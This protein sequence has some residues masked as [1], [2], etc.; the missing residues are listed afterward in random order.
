MPSLAVGRLLRSAGQSRHQP[1]HEAK[2]P[3]QL[4]NGFYLR[5]LFASLCSGFLLAAHVLHAPAGTLSIAQSA[6]SE[7]CRST[8]LYV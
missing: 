8:T 4:R 3:W 1:A 7:P 6:P 2:A 5:L